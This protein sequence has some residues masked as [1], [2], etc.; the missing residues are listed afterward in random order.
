MGCAT[1]EATVAEVMGRLVRG[2]GANQPTELGMRVPGSVVV[3]ERSSFVCH[4]MS[5]QAIYWR[6]SLAVNRIG[7]TGDCGLGGFIVSLRMKAI[8]DVGERCTEYQGRILLRLD[9]TLGFI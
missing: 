6:W 4:D 5:S 3:E 7:G 1:V 9:N 2:R 8:C